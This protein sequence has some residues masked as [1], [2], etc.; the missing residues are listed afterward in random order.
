MAT[1]KYLR[2]LIAWIPRY[3]A[4]WHRPLLNGAANCHGP[5]PIAAPLRDHFFS[6]PDSLTLILTL[7]IRISCR[8]S[9]ER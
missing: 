6:Q 4:Q 3:T 7:F 5:L 9:P 2:F 8:T 1:D